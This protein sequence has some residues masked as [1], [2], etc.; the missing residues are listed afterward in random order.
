MWD[1]AA[2]IGDGMSLVTVGQPPAASLTTHP[3]CL[4]AG[5]AGIGHR[6]VRRTSNPIL[7]MQENRVV[8]LLHISDI[9]FRSPR[10]L[11]PDQDPDRPYRTRMLQDLRDRVTE[12][13]PAH[14]I[15]VG[16]D[17]AFKGAFVRVPDRHGLD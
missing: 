12:L 7:L 4:R 16:G 6:L 14:A 3:I 1:P 8:L 9:H 13:G 17:I 2:A 5:M 11:T 10:C 15:L